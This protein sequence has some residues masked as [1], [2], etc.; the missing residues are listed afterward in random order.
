[1]VHSPTSTERYLTCPLLWKLSKEWAPRALDKAALSRIVGSGVGV[2][3]AH[4]YQSNRAA[5]HSAP[6]AGRAW[7]SAEMA[8]LL[9]AGHTLSPEMGED[10]QKL[11]EVVQKGIE[12]YI[13]Q[14]PMPAEWII[15][16][17]EGVLPSGSRTDWVAVKPNGEKVVCDLKTKRTL[18]DRYIQSTLDEFRESWQQRHYLWEYSEDHQERVREY[19][20][21]LVRLSPFK[22]IV[23]PVSVDDE[24]LEFWYQGAKGVW[25]LMDQEYLWMAASH[26]TRYGR[27]P[28]WRACLEYRLDEGLMAQEYIRKE[29]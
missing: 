2:G 22:I 4:Y 8:R 3:V 29:V 5:R 11:P 14:D 26:R 6:D 28:M 21:V 16:D 7:V 18:D 19:A 27:C 20:I 12:K 15:Q 23:D 25:G 17:I 24:S 13:A 9:G 1:M 10:A